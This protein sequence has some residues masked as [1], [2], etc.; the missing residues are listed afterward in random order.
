VGFALVVSLALSH[1]R[2]LCLLSAMDRRG[3][4]KGQWDGWRANRNGVS[5]YAASIPACAQSKASRIRI[6]SQSHR[7]STSPPRCVAVSLHTRSAPTYH[8]TVLA[9]TA[10]GRGYALRATA[11][12]RPRAST[13]ITG[14]VSRTPRRTSK[15]SQGKLLTITESHGHKGYMH[16]GLLPRT[17]QYPWPLFWHWIWRLLM[18]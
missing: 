11:G 5:I 1:S 7:T 9:R 3:P 13:S 17:I 8:D 15:K 14:P 12:R 2:T 16:Y 6:L 4:R 18:G 10:R